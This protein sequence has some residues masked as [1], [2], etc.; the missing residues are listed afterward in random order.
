MKLIFVLL[1]ALFLS[2]CFPYAKEYIAGGGMT[3]SYRATHPYP[4]TY[5]Y[6]RYDYRPYWRR[7]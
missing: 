5:G 1:S 3:Q 7:Y 6:N 4:G 2:G